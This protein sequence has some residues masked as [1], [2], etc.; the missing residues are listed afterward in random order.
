MESIIQQLKKNRYPFGMWPDPECY[1][2]ELGEAMQAKAREIGKEFFNWWV[3]GDW[4]ICPVAQFRS[5][6]TYRLR[7]DYEDEPEIRQME[8][9]A[10]NSN[11]LCMYN[12]KG[13]SFGS[14]AKVKERA[15]F[16]GFWFKPV[17][18]D[19]IYTELWLNLDVEH[20]GNYQMTH[21]THVLFR[22][23]AKE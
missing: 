3:A 4:T 13:Q 22:Q 17:Y 20:N 1:G 19:E 12:D 2:K 8:I 11:C 23:K 7:A 15:D 5:E 16:A 6:A 18:G 9:K 21:A 14:V 10:N